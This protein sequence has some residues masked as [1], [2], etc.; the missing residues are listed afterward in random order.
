M[1]YI[2]ERILK[3]LKDN[4]ISVYSFAKITGISQSL[5]HMILHFERTMKPKHF[6]AI[7]DNLPLSINEKRDLTERFLK[8]TMGDA[9]YSANSYIFDML[10]DFSEYTYMPISKKFKIPPP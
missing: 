9:R 8:I 5:L 10:K 6:Y 2:I 7:I 4:H 3:I 1:E